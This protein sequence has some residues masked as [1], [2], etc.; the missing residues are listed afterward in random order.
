[1]SSSNG[2]S[3]EDSREQRTAFQTLFAGLPEDPN[4]RL[5]ALAEVN[6]SFRRALADQLRPVV[7]ALLQEAPPADA[8]GRREL[9]HRLNHVMRD[10][11][12]AVVDPGS[13]QAA[14][15]VVEPYRLVL[16]SRLAAFG[17]E[18]T[19]ARHCGGKDDAEPQIALA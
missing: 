13:G 11:N 18:P 1:M 17:Q 16:Q 7:R 14:T 10:G 6:Y 15:V 12:L 5:D 2:E 19:V 8:Q 9:A 4:G 3:H